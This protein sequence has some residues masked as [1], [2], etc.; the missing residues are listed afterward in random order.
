MY[1]LNDIRDERYNAHRLRQTSSRLQTHR[2]IWPI[3]IGLAG[4]SALTS[5]R[6]QSISVGLLE[7]ILVQYAGI[8][9]TSNEDRAA[10]VLRALYIADRIRKSTSNSKLHIISLMRIRIRRHVNRK[11]RLRLL[12]SDLTGNTV[13]ISI[14][15]RCVKNM[16]YSTRLVRLRDSNLYCERAVL[17]ADLTVS[18]T[19]RWHLLARLA[20]HLLTDND[21]TL[22][23]RYS[24]FR[25]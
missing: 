24:L 21:A 13:G 15:C 17:T 12:S 7:S 9:L 22:A 6:H 20:I 14:A 11:V 19:K 23:F 4:L 3:R 10:A 2:S 1:V 25:E 8:S 16:S 18:I 5:T